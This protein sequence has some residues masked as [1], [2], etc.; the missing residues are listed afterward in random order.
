M[1]WKDLHRWRGL[2]GGKKQ[3]A[4]GRK[5]KELLN[6]ELKYEEQ[7]NYQNAL[8]SFFACP[9]CEKPQQSGINS[10]HL[11]ISV[12]FNQRQLTINH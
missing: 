5:Q 6:L 11:S 2:G 9:A 1:K 7:Q 10:N 8:N 12:G 3:K 4:E